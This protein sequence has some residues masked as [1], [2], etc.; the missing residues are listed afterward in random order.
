LLAKAGLVLGIL[1]GLKPVPFKTAKH[2]EED[3]ELG[4]LGGVF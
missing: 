1:Y 3:A 2:I 4:N